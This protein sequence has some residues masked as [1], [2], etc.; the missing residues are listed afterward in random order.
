MF[1]MNFPYVKKGVNT[2]LLVVR[3]ELILDNL[4]LSKQ[5]CLPNS[6]MDILECE[7][8]SLL[9]LLVVVKAR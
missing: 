5:G 2:L 3:G 9:A 6:Y 8:D 4:L 7:Y 1:W